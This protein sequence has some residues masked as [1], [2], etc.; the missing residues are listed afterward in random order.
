MP[1]IASLNGFCRSHASLHR[2][3][4]NQEHNEDLSFTIPPFT[5]DPPTEDEVHSAMAK[6]FRALACNRISNRRAATFAYISQILLTSKGSKEARQASTNLSHMFI[7]TLDLAY[8]PKY[9]KLNPAF[10]AAHQAAKDDPPD[11]R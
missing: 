7:K 2:S 11:I 1:A 3:R 10:K 9:G 6:V 8:N 4:A 5:N